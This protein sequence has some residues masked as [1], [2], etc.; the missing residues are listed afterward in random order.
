MASPLPSNEPERG[1]LVRGLGLL[2]ATTLIVGSVIGSGIFVAPSIMAGFVQTPGLL[3]GLWVIG[4]ILTLFGALAYGEMAAALPHAGGQY[5][6]LKEAF[7]PVWGFLY[8]WTFLLAIN[9]GFIAAVAVAFAKYLGV[10]LPVI[11]EGTAL[12]MVGTYK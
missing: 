11:G 2:E 8:G 4:G 12:F 6:F 1:G 10:F 3:M 5:V 9:T 7:S